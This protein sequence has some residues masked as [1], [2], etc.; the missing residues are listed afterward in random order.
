MPHLPQPIADTRAIVTP[1]GQGAE[2]LIISQMASKLFISNRFWRKVR[3][4]DLS[5]RYDCLIVT[6]GMSQR[7]MDKL[8]VGFEQEKQR[9]ITLAQTAKERQM[10]VVVVSVDKL[11]RRDKTDD[12]TQAIAP[13]TDYYLIIGDANYDNFFGK[14][15]KRHGIPITVV[16]DF[17]RAKTPLNS[18]FR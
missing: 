16:R 9:L 7:N 17:E 10:A 12:I 18:I 8:G 14:L 13:Y 1:A 5:E 11:R 6:V 3:G 4:Q 15:A 2:G